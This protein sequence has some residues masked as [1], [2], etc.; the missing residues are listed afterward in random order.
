MVIIFK[1]NLVANSPIHDVVPSIFIFD[2]CIL[3]RFLKCINTVL[4]N[5]ILNSGLDPELFDPIHLFIITHI[6]F[7][8]LLS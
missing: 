6:Q 7:L 4:F 8:C 3:T 1:D 2:T 5:L